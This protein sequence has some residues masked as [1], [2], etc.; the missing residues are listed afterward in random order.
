MNP[1]EQLDLDSTGF[2]ET[3]NP[4]GRFIET[5]V[6]GLKETQ[7]LPVSS[8]SETKR[9]TLTLW[10]RLPDERAAGI[11]SG[12]PQFTDGTCIRTSIV[13]E[14]GEH[15]IVTQNRTY[16]LQTPMFLDPLAV[17]ARGNDSDG[18]TLATHGANSNLETSDGRNP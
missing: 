10:E 1:T 8:H 18:S 15:H 17:H 13:A 2:R 7:V 4:L 6:D 3:K 9:P 12:H 11:V 14:W 5:L 16:V